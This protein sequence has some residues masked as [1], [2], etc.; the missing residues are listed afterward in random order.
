M[1]YTPPRPEPRGKAALLGGLFAADGR[2][3]LNLLPERAYRVQMGVAR[4]VTHALYLVNAPETVREVLLER[5]AEFPKHHYLADI[6]SPLIGI[7]LF[8]ANGA[9][10]TRQRRLVD[11]AFAPAGL[12]RAFPVMVAGVDAMLGRLD[13]LADGRPWD[14]DE[15][16][17]HVT[18]DIIFRTILSTPL[19]AAQARQVHTA[20]RRYQE[21]AQRVMGLSALRLYTGWHR[22][23]CRRQAGAIRAAFAAPI[24]ARHAAVRAGESSVPDDMLGALMRARDPDT[25]SG[26]SEDEVIDQVGTLFL[27][28]HET[29]ASTLAWA[30]YLLACQ[31]EL[32]QAVR[33]EAAALWAARG[34]AFGDTRHLARAHDVFRETLRLYP[35]I[36]FYLR[37][38]AGE[39]CLRDKAVPHG[40]MVAVSPWVVHRHRGLWERP[41]EFDP[42]RF[43]SGEGS[44]E[45]AAYIP[46]GLGPRACPGA[47]FATQESVL[48]LAQ[49][50][51]RYRVTTVPGHTPRPTARLT[52]RSAN[53]VRLALHRLAEDR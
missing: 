33:D 10:W 12:R 8:N 3:M 4:V 37:E 53:G 52:L 23:R 6:L 46:F 36:A 39:T 35:P 30:L 48:I 26:L 43:S 41:D 42:S 1:G 20:F 19:E 18:A 44:A 49:I 21:N 29:S 50:V 24:R 16:M 47:G 9:D 17:S 22:A 51:R 5:W 28:G 15:A 34:P 40:A 31:P 32:Q 45:K 13:T 38:S 25:G 11:Q 2:S 14:A 27:A 7:S